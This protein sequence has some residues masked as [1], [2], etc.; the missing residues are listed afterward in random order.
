MVRAYAE[1][2]NAFIAT[3]DSLPVEYAL[4]EREPE[5]WEDWH[6]AAVYKIRNTLLGTFEAKLFRT[7]LAAMGLAEP[8][9]KL[10]KGYPRGNLLTVPPG[11]EYEGPLLDGLEALD[12]AVREANWLGEIEPGSNGWSISGGLTETG[13]R[14]GGGRFPPRP[15]RALRLLP[16]APVLSH[17]SRHR[18]LRARHAGGPPLLSQRPRGLGHDPRRRRYTRSVHRAFSRNRRWPG[19]RVQRPVVARRG[20]ARVDPRPRRSV[21]ARGGHHHP[22]RTR[23]RRR[24]GRRVRHRHQRPRPAGRHRLAGRRPRR[25]EGGERRRPAPRLPQLDRP[26]QQLR[27]GRRGGELRLPPRGADPRPGRGQRLAGRAGLER[28]P[29]VGRLHTRTTSCRRRSIRSAGT[30]SPATSASPATTIPTTWA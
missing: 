6:C 21:R 13:M 8:L 12:A 26:R 7:R 17:H 1:G 18:P 29:R 24:P 23:H 5:P 30:P 3:T 20:P 11:A 10:M 9:A 25:H 14:P 19:I 2:V 15:G 4:L 16:G 22:S 28:R 27:R